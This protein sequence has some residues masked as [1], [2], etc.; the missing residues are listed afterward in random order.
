MNNINI[1]YEELKNQG[2]GSHTMPRE[3]KI[4]EIPFDKYIIKIKLSPENEFL[5][6]Q[7]VMVN[8]EFL[9]Y[10]QKIAA[11][12]ASGYHDVEEYYREEKE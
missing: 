7:G 11:L 3:L 6:I 1:D 10:S 4:V 9:S 12:S 8:K 5:G 2:T